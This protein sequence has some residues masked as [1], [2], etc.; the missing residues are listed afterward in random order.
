MNEIQYIEDLLACVLGK[1]GHTFALRDSDL[2]L[3]NSFDRQIVKGVALTDRQYNLLKLKL[4]I[5]TKQF[6]KNNIPNWS[7]A[8]QSISTEFREI[9][10]SKYISLVEFDNIVKNS[11]SHYSLKEGLYIKIRFPFN[12]KYI[13]KLESIIHSNNNKT[14]FHEKNSHEHY[15]KFTALNCYK[16]HSAF[17]DWQIDQT[18][19]DVSKKV[20]QIYDNK[21]AFIPQYKNNKFLNVD[22][23][24]ATQLQST[25]KLKIADLSIAYGFY[26]SDIQDNTLLDKIAYRKQP[27]V[28]ANIETNSLYDIVNC[29]DYLERYPLIVCIDKDDAFDQVKEMHTAISKYVPN[30]LQS[31]MFRVESSDKKNN[32]LNNFVKENILNNWV[33]KTTKVVYIKKDKLPKVL[34][35]TDFKPR[36]AVCKSSLRSNRLVTNYVNFNCDLIVYNDISLSSFTETYYTKGFNNWQLVD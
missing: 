25:E 24:V 33:D 11:R 2:S 3:L 35:K 1:W 28:L 15:F 7:A 5:Y 20:Q 16:L 36:T 12:K 19:T 31:V 22:T 34:L 21:D 30:N 13:T 17:P 4:E 14:Y 9:D 8:L 32:Q 6:E 26:V 10:R 27:T 18:I 23:N 29:I